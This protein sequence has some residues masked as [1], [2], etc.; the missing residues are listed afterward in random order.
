MRILFDGFWWSDGPH[1][2]R[3]V[4]RAFVLHW[5]REFG[6]DELTVA[7]RWQHLE[8]ARAEL[9]ARVQLV[10]TRLWPQ[11]LSTIVEL[12]WLARREKADLCLTHN[13]TPLFGRSLVFVHDMLF[14]TAPQW[15]TRTERLYFSLMPLTARR[16]RVVATSSR[17]EAA[18]IRQAA[19]LPR[20]VVPV[21]LAVPS[22]L[23]HAVPE[24]WPE[25]QGLRGFLLVVG[26]L[27]VRK[28]LALALAAALRS[29]RVSPE[30]PVVVVGERSGLET[31]LPDGLREAVGRG[32]LRFV[33][34]VDDAKLAWLYQQATL[35]VFLSLDEGFGLPCLE[36]LHFGTPI[37]AS[38]IAVFREILRDQ[39]WYVDPSSEVAVA[40]AISRALDT[41]ARHGRRALQRPEDLGYAWSASV[42]RLRAAALAAEGPGAA[43]TGGGLKK[44]LRILGTRGV[45]SAHGGFETFAER[46][47]LHLVARGWRVTVYCQRDGRGAPSEDTWQG[48]HRV[49]IPVAAEGS[50]GTIVFDWIATRHAARAGEPCL[51]LG[52]NTAV[53]CAL[54]R[55]AQVPNVINMDGIEWQRAKWGAVARAWFRLNEHA[56]S[57]LADHLVADHPEIANHLARSVRRERIS[58]IAYGADELSGLSDAPVRA[59]HLE[60]GRYLTLIAR[61]EPEN[62]VL[63]VVQ[64]FSRRPRGRVLAVLGHYCDSQSYHR[65]VRAAASKEVMFLGALYDKPVVQALR[66]HSW[67]YVHGHSVGGTNPSLVEALG[68]G[69]GVLA[70]DNLFNR[71]VAGDAAA[72]F[73]DADSC[74]AR[75]DE[76]LADETR[77][78]PLRAAARRRFQQAYTWPQILGQYEALLTRFLPL[79][80]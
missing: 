77:L 72:Y 54:L 76:L 50:K 17:H 5:E 73:S 43:G 60:P 80:R 69:N 56:G 4:M 12:P 53:F 42:R 16:A 26:R 79:R 14:V 9:P 24:P 45:P 29:G 49:N 20:E 30:F 2:N 18:R 62:S 44:A 65:A 66:Q 27:N 70:H 48:V 37:L 25:L 75:L 55:L 28:N 58:T 67:L 8:E 34:F 7:V 15:F 13:F 39:A 59:L 33:G 38:D 10:G 22:G 47:A 74:A 40:E 64:A 63:E 57:W 78:L 23:Q 32:S 11:G 21:G 61:P 19:R 36:A 41:L 51:T 71:G 6:D 1:S 52:Y 3:Q 46:L 68:A 31:Q 35:F